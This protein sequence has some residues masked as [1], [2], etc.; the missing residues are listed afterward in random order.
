M[1]TFKQHLIEGKYKG[2]AQGVGS[3]AVDSVEDS[4]IGAHNIHIPAVLERINA[5]VG[6][7]GDQEYIRPQHAIDS[8]KEKLGRIGIAFKSEPVIE[9]KSGTAETG[10]TQFGGRFGKDI[11][12][13]DIN[14][15][16]ITHRLGKELKVKFQYETLKNGATRVYAQLV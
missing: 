6:S 2:D 4:S 5:F 13:S 10:L 3:T 15:D 11:D 14:D 8:L 1:K 12:G 9:G 16:G 7:I